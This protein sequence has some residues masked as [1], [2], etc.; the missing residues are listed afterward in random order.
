MTPKD[1]KMPS[2]LEDY[3]IKVDK[4]LDETKKPR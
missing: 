1:G 3:D 2:L 4:S